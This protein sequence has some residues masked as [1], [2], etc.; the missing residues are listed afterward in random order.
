MEQNRQDKK[1]HETAPA[2]WITRFYHHR[3]QRDHEQQPQKYPTNS[4][5]GL[6]TQNTRGFRDD[7]RDQW[8][9]SW[10]SRIEGKHINFILIQET[11]V[12]TEQEASNLQQQWARTWGLQHDATKPLSFWSVATTSS[13]GVAILLRPGIT[14]SFE[15]RVISGNEGRIISISSPT[16]T[17]VNI[18]APNHEQERERFF[19]DIA[20]DLRAIT[21]TWFLAGDFNCVLDPTMDTT[22]TTTRHARPESAT[23]EWL[24][25]DLQLRDGIETATRSRHESDLHYTHFQPASD[26]GARLDRCYATANSFDWIVS[27]A[28]IT[29]RVASDHLG[30]VTWMRD[31]AVK[32]K[33][34]PLQ[35]LLYPIRGR[36]PEAIKAEIEAEL[37]RV[38]A[39][40]ELEKWPWEETLRHITDAL[41]AIRKTENQRA[42]R[43]IKKWERRLRERVQTRE[44]LIQYEQGRLARREQRRRGA[45]LQQAQVDTSTIYTRLNRRSPNVFTEMEGDQMRSI[46]DRLA[47]AWAPLLTQSHAKCNRSDQRRRLSKLCTVPRPH[48]LSE[49][50]NDALL[51]RITATEV[52]ATIKELGANKAAGADRLNNDFYRDWAALL[53]PTLAR[54]STKYWTEHRCQPPLETQSS[55]PYQKPATHPRPWTTAQSRY[56]NRATRSSRRFLPADSSAALAASSVPT[57][58]GLCAGVTW[59]TTSS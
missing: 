56:Y 47:T 58:T 50:D 54:E 37:R 16:M 46:A 19:A 9:A 31:P 14:T 5:F 15:Q 1:W 7:S 43:A 20:P 22:S 25:R 24:V 29:P 40:A 49:Q 17:I 6:L 39:S 28:V 3:K 57:K 36:D 38:T 41:K 4:T 52:E 33:Q 11:H 45:R 51:A 48:I 32:P 35:P 26:N 42:R 10:K 55:Y 30:L 23:L 13:V 53:A 18:Y 59:Q 21:G 44:E 27:S 2:T 8:M 12:G 34:R